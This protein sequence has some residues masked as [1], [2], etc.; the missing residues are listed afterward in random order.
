MTRPSA[1]KSSSTVPLRTRTIRKMEK[2]ARQ[3]A[4]HA[5]TGNLR[6]KTRNQERKNALGKKLGALVPEQYPIDPDPAVKLPAD[7]QATIARGNAAFRRQGRSTAFRNPKGGRQTP[8]IITSVID[9]EIQDRRDANLDAREEAAEGKR[10]Q[11]PMTNRLRAVMIV[12]DRLMSEGVPFGVGPNSRMNK[13]VLKWLNDR[14][15]RSGDSRKSRR[16]EITPTAVRAL[17]KQV[18]AE[19][20]RIVKPKT[21]KLTYKEKIRELLRQLHERQASEAD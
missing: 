3:V 19:G 1:P 2:G 21:R 15:K 9:Q 8:P 13:A 12:V 5:R 4:I 18:K 16:K 10:R 20:Q 7:V 6:R 17:L 11:P 14:A